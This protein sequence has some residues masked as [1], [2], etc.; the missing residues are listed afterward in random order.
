MTQSAFSER[1]CHISVIKDVRYVYC[2]VMLI[3]LWLRVDYV[4]VVV[5]ERVGTIFMF[6]FMSHL[7]DAVCTTGPKVILTINVC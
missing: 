4:A 2:Y 7:F 3:A 1:C 5:V 6:R